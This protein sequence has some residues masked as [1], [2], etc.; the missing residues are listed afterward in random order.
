MH[1]ARALSPKSADLLFAQG[2]VADLHGQ[3]RE[4]LEACVDYL[5]PH[6]A[7]KELVV[8]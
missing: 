6:M 7:D 1:R 4:A 3:P 2:I 8:S 5:G